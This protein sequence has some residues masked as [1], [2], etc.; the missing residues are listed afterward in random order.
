M[1]FQ[2]FHVVKLLELANNEFCGTK[3]EI[4]IESG[5][6]TGDGSGKVV[7]HIE[8]AKSMGLI[9]YEKE[10]SAYRLVL[11][12]L[13]KCVYEQDPY[14]LED[15]TKWVCNYWLTD[16]E[17]GIPQ[18]Y[19]FMRGIPACFNQEQAS[20]DIEKKV[21]QYFDTPVYMPVTYA[22]YTADCFESLGLLTYT[23]S[24]ANGKVVFNEVLST[25]E[26]KNVY[27]YTLLKS[28]EMQLTDYKEIT[29]N[30]VL[31]DLKWNRAFGFS[32]EEIL[33]VLDELAS[34][35]IITLNKQLTP[36]TLI[37]VKEADTFLP[38]LYDLIF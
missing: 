30:Q 35:G 17:V 23:N 5:I 33:N 36:M 10:K 37:R 31:E 20:A 21:Q 25:M 27:A 6:P 26:N 28:W 19:Y 38:H 7:G 1:P 24:K 22:T 12:E 18:W 9:D 4:S 16:R 14:L 3:E 8:F 29:I 34:E 11:T 15:V 2:L 32:Y 13:G